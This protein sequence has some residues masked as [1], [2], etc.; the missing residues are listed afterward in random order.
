MKSWSVLG[1]PRMFVFLLGSPGLLPGFWLPD[2][3]GARFAS[4]ELPGPRRPRRMPSQPSDQIRPSRPKSRT[5]ARRISSQKVWL[6]NKTKLEISIKIKISIR[7]SFKIT[8]F[9]N[10]SSQ[11]LSSLKGTDAI[12][13]RPSSK[14]QSKTSPKKV[15][16]TCRWQTSSRIRG[17][18][19]RQNLA[20]STNQVKPK[21]WNREW[22]QEW[23]RGPSMA[24]PQTR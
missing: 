16:G 14:I 2:A 19:L 21:E 15:F 13:F 1:N 18:S 7:I 20:D 3:G 5:L 4:L 23:N 12:F 9:H 8:V 6:K 17:W 11:Y 24:I 22:N 10:Y